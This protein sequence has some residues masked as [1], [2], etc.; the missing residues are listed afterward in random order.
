VANIGLYVYLI[1]SLIKYR[2]VYLISLPRIA[3]HEYTLVW[4]I[5]HFMRARNIPFLYYN[6]SLTYETGTILLGH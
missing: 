6:Q 1:K 3:K 5:P 4:F 2:R